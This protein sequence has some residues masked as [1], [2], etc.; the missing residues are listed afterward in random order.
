M[1]W[2]DTLTLLISFVLQVLG[3]TTGPGRGHTVGSRTI[4][5]T[6]FFADDTLST[7]KMQERDRHTATD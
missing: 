6:H 7:W 4:M 5:K 1:K 3:S 2:T